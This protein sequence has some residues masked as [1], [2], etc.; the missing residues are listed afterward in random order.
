LRGA[1]LRFRDRFAFVLLGAVALA[2]AV[3][4]I[5][6]AAT[7]TVNT[8]GDDGPGPDCLPL[9]TLRGAIMVANG[10]PGPDTIEFDLP[11]EGPQT[12]D[13][14]SALPTI[15]DPVTIDGTT[16]DGWIGPPI[17]MLNWASEQAGVNGL[18]V[19]GGGTTIRGLVVSGFS[20]SGITLAG[21]GN[22][23]VG[24]YVGT[25]LSGAGDVGNLLDGIRVTSAENAIGGTAALDR[26]VISGNG[27]QGIYIQ[28]FGADDNVVSG[29]YIGTNA[30]GTA[31]LPNGSDG[32][33]VNIGR[34]NTIG[35][36]A[37][38]AGN[39][40]SGNSSNGVSILTPENG[41]L[42]NRIGTNA[43][44]SAAIPNNVGISVSNDSDNDS[45]TTI[46]GA[47]DGAGNLVSGNL[48]V[49][50][51]IAG[52][53]AGTT[54]YGNIIG[55]DRSGSEGVPNGAGVLVFPSSGVTIGG[56]GPIGNRISFNSGRGVQVNG[57]S[58]QNT[59]SGNAIDAN[60]GVGIDLGDDG[61]TAND[62]GDGD[63]G[64]NALQ[65]FPVLDTAETNGTDSIVIHGTLN[66]NS[67]NLARIEFF[68]SPSCDPS[69]NGEG[70][71]FLGATTVDTGGGTVDVVGGFEVPVA[72]GEAVTAT[73]TI[74]G[75]TSEFSKCVEATGTET[76]GTVVNSYLDIDDGSCDRTN[77]TLREAINA[78]NAA[79][80]TQTITFAIPFACSL[81]PCL[82]QIEVASE[83]PHLTDP[84]VIDG[85]TQFP[86]Q[87][88]PGIQVDGDGLGETNGIVIEGGSSTVR[89]LSLVR[90]TGAA[91][92]LPSDGNT[93]TGNY[94]GTDHTWTTTAGNGR[95]ISVPGTDNTIGGTTAAARNVIAS[96][97][98][99]VSLLG[100]GNH[101]LGNSIGTDPGGT[102]DLGNILQGVRITGNG[103]EV[104]GAAAG[105]GNVI[106]FNGTSATG[107]DV[108]SGIRNA[109]LSNSIRD[110]VGL[111][112]DLGSD[113][114]TPNDSGDAD[115]GA[116]NLQNFPVLT[117]AEKLG[118]T[119]VVDGGLDSIASTT[120]RLEFFH[121]PDCDGSQ[122][123][124]GDTLLGSTPVTT[125]PAGEASFSVT[126]PLAVATGFVTATATDAVGNT[127]EFSTCAAVA[128]AGEAVAMN[129]PEE[130]V[131]Q[132]DGG[133]TVDFSRPEIAGPLSEFYAALGLHFLDGEEFTPIFY[134][135]EERQTSSP[136]WSAVLDA[137]YPFSSADV[138]LTMTFDRGQT[139]VGFFMG[140]GT[141]DGTP[142]ATLTAYNSDGASLGSVTRGVPRND[143][144]TYFG[145]QRAEGGIFKVTLDYGD[146]DLSEEI[147]DLCF[148]GP[149]LDEGPSE[150][151]TLTVDQGTNPAGSKTDMFPLSALPSNQLM[152]FSGAPS[153]APV[154]SIPVGS[155]PV[156]SIPVGSIPVGSIPVG[157]IPVGSI[158]VGSI[159][160]GSIPVGSI[161]LNAVPV[162]SI[163]LD[164]VLLTSLPVDW[165]PILAGTPLA[166]LVTQTSTLKDV[167]ANTVARQR[168]EALTLAQTGLARS[169]LGGVPFAGLLLGEKHLNQIPPPGAATWC[170][171][172]TNAGGSCTGVSTSTN[173]VVGLAV[174][175]LPVGS[176]P[177]GSI[178]VGSIAGG[179]AGTPV[180]SIPV[181]SIDIAATRLAAILVKDIPNANA[182]VDCSRLSNCTGTETLGD[183]AALNPSAIRPTATLAALQAV[184]GNITL[185]ELIIGIL[186]RSALN[187]EQF[188]IEGIQLFKPNTVRLRYTVDYDLDCAKKDPFA[189]TVKMPLGFMVVPGTSTVR[190]GNTDAIAA[191]NPTTNAK[192]GARWTG[193][194]DPCGAL[195]T[196]HIRLSFDALSGFD[197]TTATTGVSSA[198]VV[199][200]GTV[201]SVT[202]R[203]PVVVTQN[204]EAND[205]PAGGP[206]IQPDQLVI[207]H[208]ARSG[209]QEVFK[210]PIPTAPGTVTTVYLSHMGDDAGQP[211]K[212]ADFDLVIGV[213]ATPPLQSSPVGSIPVGSIPIEDKGSDVDNRTQALPPETLQDIPVGSIPVGSIS[214]NRGRSDEVAQVVSRGETG[215]YTIV[216]RGY[217]GSYSRD[218][219]VLRVKRTPAPPLPACAPRGLT[220]GAAGT[221]PPG[222]PADTKT[223]FLVNRSRMNALYGAPD[224][225]AMLTALNTMLGRPEIKGAVLEVDGN[226]N[227]RAAYA[228]W[229]ANPCD[230]EAANGV[231][232]RINDVVAGYRGSLPNL[233][234][235]V[236]LGSDDAL[237]MARVPDRV[238]VSPE[239]D[240][241]GDLQFTTANLTK[242]NAIYAAAALSYFM[243]DGAYGAFTQ[244]PWLGRELLLPQIPVSRLVETSEDIRLQLAEYV[245]A[246]G[247]LDPQSALTTAY[248]FLTDGGMS[249]GSSLAQLVAPGNATSLL[250]NWNKAQLQAAFTGKTPPDDVNSVN[251]HYSQ[252]QAQPAVAATASDLL[253]TAD[254][255]APGLDPA[256]KNRILFTMGCH[257]GY[258]VPNTVLTG[259]LPDQARDWTE[260]WARQRAA[261]YVAN[262][263]FGYGD[264]AANA[265]SER[266]M[267]I[268]AAK[269]NLAAPTGEAIGKLWN[270]AQHEYF[271]GA[272]AYDV[273]D[274]KALVEASLFGLPF[275]QI[276]G[277]TAP[278]PSTPPSP[279]FDPTLGFDVASVSVSPSL[280]RHDLTGL[281]T[282]WD[283]GGLIQTQ[284]THFRPI[285][286]RVERD[287]TVTGKTAHGVIITSLVTNDM[288]GIDP[289]L[290]QPTIDLGAHEPERNFRDTVFPANLV[291]LTRSR[292]LGGDRQKLVVNAGQ[293]RPATPAGPTGI[294]RLVQ[295]IGVQIA[296]SNSPDVTPPFIRQVNSF[297]G[298]SATIVVEVAE[299]VKRV[300]A[301]YNDTQSWQFAELQ[302]IG[303]TNFWTATV[304][305]T[306]PI[307]VAAMA[308]DAA[309][310]VGYST[311]KGFNFLSIVDSGGPDILIDSPGANTIYGVNQAVPASYF[312]SDPVGVASCVG[313]VPNGTNVDT[314]A[315]PHT[316]TVTA[317]DLAGRESTKTVTYFVRYVFEGFFQPV[318]NP[319]KLNQGVAGRTYPV[320]WRLR[321]AAGAPVRSL[322]AVRSI[323]VK[324][325]SCEDR[326]IDELETSET[327]GTSELVYD[328]AGEQFVYHWK[329]QKSWAGTCRRLVI[330]LADGTTHFADFRLR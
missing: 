140:N 80:G 318:D 319:P 73:A 112:I 134:A 39:L 195:T 170:G 174:G 77:C 107:V 272:G 115:T 119:V 88:A 244:I 330:E 58:A 193:F 82:V 180:G 186:P 221:L 213:P 139:A 60:G 52:R 295:S 1:F 129:S 182:V 64:P 123:G 201:S 314:T 290:A 97:D 203:A 248:D 128:T 132:A 280:T 279:V 199:A 243:T 67:E 47:A 37:A 148:T 304:P 240:F 33:V 313:T 26:N 23:V 130:C 211:G 69:D 173:T 191:P 156:G 81:A 45:A 175:G 61:V 270:D 75:S 216:V 159:P 202:N 189:I 256:F 145:I 229:D 327:T 29:N 102:R 103:N 15:T 262:T 125:T 50:I 147:D 294:E 30:A 51:W 27:R 63:S 260:T 57:A 239:S 251:A 84:V 228:A 12:I 162:G 187:W 220:I 55:A 190:F 22:T 171:A 266:L 32:V 141:T 273:Y 31:A 205:D 255:P 324:T 86:S 231:V 222:V 104:G 28:F 236:N 154:G 49:G 106:A 233:S 146:T 116:N 40:I 127:S 131:P 232:R 263:G 219:Y 209:D 258:N 99:G 120:F 34:R 317:R 108:V 184:L 176:I 90:F 267:S 225:T 168:F 286:P 271:Q 137:E 68:A 167:Y 161:G 87:S 200:G 93:V 2:L 70:A 157:S 21:G 305:A 328:L 185:N 158:P 42:G 252:W 247:L 54:I 59:I 150:G 316:F 95:G 315:G 207:G 142:T 326:P 160:V 138:P 4:G 10:N 20:G 325:I 164:Q 212:P 62:A 310:N 192:T 110:S 111:G 48:S 269:L 11:G 46:G 296:Y 281:G 91:I 289:V 288:N 234:Y 284:V 308:Q 278:P 152:S 312:C 13:I 44:G 259:P 172:I 264:T 5:A 291:N 306:Q 309:G 14:L 268:F 238:S 237:P 166:G 303:G 283:A 124:E 257:G 65:N 253:T 53:A 235:I 298:N 197:L 206:M 204:W 144:T 151:L 329:T 94:V 292:A 18:T 321:D 36:T 301:I 121:T 226:A 227:V 218:P 76:G 297:M 178:P 311:N 43:D 261:I 163:G 254:V 17:V 8:P 246:E 101:V 302:Q 300:A 224:T 149:P 7:Y 282:F 249:V 143:V 265:L 96:N 19:T 188:P 16:E 83:L 179:I 214:A 293:F 307:E 194:P 38:G 114:V 85:N 217:N 78:A 320:K 287:V 122:N 136:P 299:Q 277:A 92:Y 3:G 56:P 169:V 25:D 66:T 35:G 181:G 117:S 285:Q 223:L 241:A 275:W 276:S 6:S 250:A 242:G 196:Q 24:S 72:V 274:E 9:C 210:T 89:G 113:G 215:V 323:S 41:I 322:A 118:G 153:A 177:V 165:S 198:T 71:R 126:L 230:V 109:I 105:E 135:N 79:A 100:D 245:L 98:T 155:I 74:G 208:I 133:R 183:A